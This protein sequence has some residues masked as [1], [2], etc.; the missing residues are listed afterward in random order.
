LLFIRPKYIISSHSFTPYYEDNPLR[1]FEIGLMFRDK[2][3]LV[4]A[5]EDAFINAGIKCRLN[6]PYDMKD[7]V[8]HA[9]ESMMSWTYPDVTEVVLIEFRNDYCIDPV[10]RKRV[11]DAML[12]VIEKLNN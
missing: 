9:Q 12:P 8:C 4:D 7:G 1:D 11:I 6:E 3:R 5:L 10:W 2:G